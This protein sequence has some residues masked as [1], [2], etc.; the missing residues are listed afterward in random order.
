MGDVFKNFTV[1]VLSE[2]HRSLSATR[3]AYPST[4]AGEGDKER[5]LAAIAVNS[6]SAMGEDSAV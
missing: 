2:L 3:R 4:L 1:D 5:V 6:S